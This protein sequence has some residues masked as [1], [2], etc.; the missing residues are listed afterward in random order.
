[1]VIKAQNRMI[2]IVSIL[3]RPYVALAYRLARMGR[4]LLLTTGY[5]YTL[6]RAASLDVMSIT[7]DD[8]R[9]I[10]GRG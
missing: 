4:G 2:P 3:V 9:S 5:L 6:G 10:C 1:M 8:T 7:K